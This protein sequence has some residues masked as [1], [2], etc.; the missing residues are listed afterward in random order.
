MSRINKK[1]VTSRRIALPLFAFL[2]LSLSFSTAKGTGSTPLLEFAGDQYFQ[3]NKNNTM[4]TNE[5]SKKISDFSKVQQYIDNLNK[6]QFND[7]RLPTKQELFDLFEI[8]DLKNNG[9][10]KVRVEG[11]YWLVNEEGITTVGT[12][13]IGDGCGPERNFYSG[14]K[15]YIRAVRLLK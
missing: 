11:R 4:W 3:N 8:F 2:F 15:G 7:W 10:V 12:W 1:M 14:E 6:G 5:R 9:E 13:E